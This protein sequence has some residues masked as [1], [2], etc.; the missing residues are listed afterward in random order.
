MDAG[1]ELLR[2]RE[3]DCRELHSRICQTCCRL[4]KYHEGKLSR[5]LMQGSNV[6]EHHHAYIRS[7]CQAANH[8]ALSFNRSLQEIL[9]CF[10]FMATD[11]V[12]Q[13]RFHLGS[14]FI[15]TPSARG[16]NSLDLD[17]LTSSLV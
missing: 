2:S 12:V 6:R 14:P 15:S 9:L 1:L 4:P 11:G 16:E 7:K 17:S 8:F 10:T 3:K 5:G 13:D